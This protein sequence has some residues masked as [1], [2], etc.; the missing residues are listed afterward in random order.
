MSESRAS[1]NLWWVVVEACKERTFQKK[2]PFSYTTWNTGV[3]SA[4]K[5]CKTYTLCDLCCFVLYSTFLF[6]IQ[7][8][9]DNISAHIFLTPPKAYHRTWLASR[10]FQ[11]INTIL[12]SNG[13]G[14]CK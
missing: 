4:G 9:E 3:I 13:L 2:R 1:F 10:K 8:C 11:T 7:L 12:V 5:A 6:F 14:D